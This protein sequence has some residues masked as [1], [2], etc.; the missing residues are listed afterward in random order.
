MCAA[1]RGF[2][3]RIRSGTVTSPHGAIAQLV[4]RIHGMDE[5]A[6][7]IPA[8]STAAGLLTLHESLERAGFALGGFVAGEGCFT[9]VERPQ[10]A[11]NGRPRLRFRFSV[12]VVEHD[13]PLLRA[14]QTFLGC[15]SVGPVRRTML[16]TWRPQVVLSVDRSTDLVARVVPFADQYLLESQKRRQFVDWRDQLLAYVSRPHRPRGHCSIEGCESPI[17]GRG[18]CRR[19]YYRA[20][21]Y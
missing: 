9:A 21:G 5:A 7:S 17:R 16:D 15:G 3:E 4:E 14:L 8:S 11:A 1:C 6:G 20:T 12:A 19:H 10:R 2:E 13:L 18:L